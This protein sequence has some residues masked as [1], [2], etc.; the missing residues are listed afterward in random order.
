MK[1]VCVQYFI[2]KSLMRYDV[3]FNNHLE[4]G[5]SRWN[6]FNYALWSAEFV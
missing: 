1:N 6:G 3:S 2:N 5:F 4:M